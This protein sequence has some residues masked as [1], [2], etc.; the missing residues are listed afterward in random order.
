MD[1]ARETIKS[2]AQEYKELLELNYE[3]TASHKDRFPMNID[4]AMLFQ[5]EDMGMVHM[6]TCRIEDKLVGYMS[7]MV[8]PN[9][10]FMT[11][12]TAYTDKYMVHSD[13]RGHG[14]GR[15]LLIKT[16]EWAKELKCER[17]FGGVRLNQGAVALK[18]YEDLG[19]EKIETNMEKVL[20]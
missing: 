9:I 18:M 2:I 4:W 6:T 3:C 19:F 1:F 20:I 13:H 16:I 8:M 14:I 7:F 11:S 15:K 5:L 12:S 17:L 10:N